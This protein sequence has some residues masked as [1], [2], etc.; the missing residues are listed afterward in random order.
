MLKVQGT[1]RDEN[2]SAYGTVHAPYSAS[3]ELLLWVQNSKVF[4]SY[5]SS[6]F[7]NHVILCPRIRY[8]AKELQSGKIS[9]LCFYE[10]RENY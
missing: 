2:M 10:P 3:M 6:C 7:I 4:V 5:I 1:A 8:S 9:Y